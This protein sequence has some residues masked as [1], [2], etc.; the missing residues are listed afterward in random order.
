MSEE[1]LTNTDHKKIFIGK[2]ME[3]D[4]KKNTKLLSELKEIVMNEKVELIDSKMREL[5]ST[6]IRPEEANKK[7]SKG[8]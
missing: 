7:T 2:P 5:V 8:A 6:Y 1:G 3:F 4:M